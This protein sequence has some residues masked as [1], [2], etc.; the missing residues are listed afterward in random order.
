MKYSMGGAV[1]FLADE[2]REVA[3]D[4]LDVLARQGVVGKKMYKQTLNRIR[5]TKKREAPSRTSHEVKM[6]SETPE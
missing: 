5:E 4:L 2:D 3:R 1:S 6:A